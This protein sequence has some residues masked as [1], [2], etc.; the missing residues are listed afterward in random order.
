[1]NITVEMVKELREATGAG[2]LDA[3]KALEAANGDFDEATVILREKGLARVAKKSGR[4]A[5]EGLIE[6]YAHPGNRVG[7]ILEINCETDFVARNEEFVELAH[8]IALQIAA[9]SPR[10]VGKDDVPEADLEAERELLT[11]QAL[12]EGKPEQ[13]VAKIVDGRMRKFYEEYCL[14]E[15]PFVKDDSM[16]IQD[17]V[18]TAISKLG[19]NIVVRRFERYELGESL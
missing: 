14:L 19:E 6:M 4:S 9:M 11:K 1:M 12:A 13:I 15:Q 16:L 18:N 2:V 7:V 5:N 3:K 10:Y 8:D 17:M